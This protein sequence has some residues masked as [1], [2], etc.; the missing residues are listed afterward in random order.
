[1][2][3]GVLMGTFSP[4]LAMAQV[5]EIGLG[6]YSLIVM[7]GLGVLIST[8][9]FNLFLM[10]LPVEG[11]P[12]EFDDYF[13]GSM[14]QHSMGAIGG[15]LW[16]LGATAALVAAT[17]KGDAHLPQMTVDLISQSAPLLAT[18][19]GLLAWRE[20]KEGDVRV[21]ISAVAMLLAFAGGVVA[22]SL[23]SFYTRT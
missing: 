9:V 12:L 16:A 2:I 18:L 14:R 6:P 5:P 3:G 17:P 23:A 19:F 20:Y 13:K 21:K 10:N 1:M 8:F 22:I 4:L 7:F 11:D 15:G